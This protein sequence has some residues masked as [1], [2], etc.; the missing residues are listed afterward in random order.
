MQLKVLKVIVCNEVGNALRS[1]NS[2][3]AKTSTCINCSVLFSPDW[4]AETKL[5]LNLLCVETEEFDS[6]LFNWEGVLSSTCVK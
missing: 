1:L 5:N 4:L 6:V 2:Q 3:T